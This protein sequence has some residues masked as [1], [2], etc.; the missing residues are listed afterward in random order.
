MTSLLLLQHFPKHARTRRKQKRLNELKASTLV[1]L[2]GKKFLD[3]KT[4]ACCGVSLIIFI[5]F[6]VFGVRIL[7]ALKSAFERSNKITEKD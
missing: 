7:E 5:P 2:V 4:C 6:V 1:A 3:V